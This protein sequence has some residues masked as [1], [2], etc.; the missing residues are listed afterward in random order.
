MSVT[1]PCHISSSR[2]RIR[3]YEHCHFV[4]TAQPRDS[5]GCNQY[6]AD[7]TLNDAID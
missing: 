6:T 1:D 4:G 3:G 7:T 5:S 2:N